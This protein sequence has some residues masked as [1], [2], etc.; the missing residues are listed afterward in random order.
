[1]Q[2]LS[3]TD[4]AVHHIKSIVSDADGEPSGIRIGVK[5]KPIPHRHSR[6]QCCHLFVTCVRDDTLHSIFELVLDL[7]F[8]L[9]I[10]I[11]GDGGLLFGLG[12]VVFVACGLSLWLHRKEIPLHKEKV[13][14]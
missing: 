7:V 9:G 5:K 14:A 4:Q 11:M 2:V 12:I 8:V 6:I 13:A 1:M 3:L 10:D